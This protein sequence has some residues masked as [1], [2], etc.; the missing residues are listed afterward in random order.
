[1]DLGIGSV[2]GLD[3]SWM[4][5]GE[6]VPISLPVRRGKERELVWT[7]RQPDLLDEERPV[8]LLGGGPSDRERGG[9]G[10]AGTVG[11]MASMMDTSRGRD[12]VLVRASISVFTLSRLKEYGVRS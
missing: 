6:I 7:A 12:K 11:V 1:M 10:V 9:G 3:G 5:E 4:V 2:S 8:K